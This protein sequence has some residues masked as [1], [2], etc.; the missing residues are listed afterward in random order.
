MTYPIIAYDESWSLDQAYDKFVKSYECTGRHIQRHDIFDPLNGIGK[1]FSSHEPGKLVT[2]IVYGGNWS[3]DE[4]REIAAFV[5]GI[6]N[7]R[8]PFV[9]GTTSVRILSKHRNV[10]G[11]LQEYIGP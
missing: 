1:V 11:A 2:F 3:S 9:T 5:E 7:V 6:R 8:S 4:A 10:P